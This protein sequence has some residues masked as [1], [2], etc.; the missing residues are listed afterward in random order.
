MIVILTIHGIGFQNSPSAL[1]A[2]DG[3]ADALHAGLCQTGQLAGGVLGDD[4]NRLAA[5]GR[6]PVYVSSSFPPDTNN[7]EDGLK[8]LGT[9]A[10]NT[11][12]P[13]GMPLAPDGARFAHVALVYSHL[14][15]T[16]GDLVAT[17][18]MGVLGAPSLTH[19]A[20]IGGIA[21]L[22]FEDLRVLHAQPGPPTPSQRL[23]ANAAQHHGFF[24]TVLH[25]QAQDDSGPLSTL[26]QVQDD[27]AAYVV[28]NEHRERVRGFIRDAAYRILARPD[29]DGLIVNGHSNGTVMGFDLIAAMSPPTAERVRLLVTA[30]CPLRKYVDFMDWGIDA[31]SFFFMPKGR[32]TNFY[33]EADPVA[34]PL[35]PPVTWKRGQDPPPGGGDGLFTVYDPLSGASASVAVADVVVDNVAAH[36]G[37]GLPAHNYWDNES[38]CK[39]L[40]ALIAA[41]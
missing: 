10:G 25:T 18:A 21:R 9:W 32:W 3:Y 16:Q 29:V 4:P 19:Y 34:D 15:E 8:R 22:A 36:S 31:R 5:R 41:S 38:F 6:G 39:Q 30:G 40:A 2:D 17:A 12:D 1:D 26:R 7:S 33:D 14:E 20:T 13:T 24:S 28:R 23:R 35:Q 11:V 37:G 27:V